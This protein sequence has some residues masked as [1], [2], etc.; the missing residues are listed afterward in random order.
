M[1]LFG[2]PILDVRPQMYMVNILNIYGMHILFKANIA[3]YYLHTC[4]LCPADIQQ[5]D[6]S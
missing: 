2:C 3:P 4:G 1:R 5:C 6:N